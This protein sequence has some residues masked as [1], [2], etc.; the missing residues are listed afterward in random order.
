[1]TKVVDHDDIFQLTVLDDPE[2]F[3][4]E[5]ILGL[6]AVFSMQKSQDCLL[7]SVE[8]VNDRFGVVKS[9]SSEDVDVVVLAHSSEEFEAVGSDIESELITFVSMG[10]VGFLILVKDRVNQRFVEV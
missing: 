10:D 7:G 3:D 1:M 6:H 4:E 9:A 8:V 5:A 2:V